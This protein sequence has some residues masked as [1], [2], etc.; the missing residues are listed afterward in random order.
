LQTQGPDDNQ[1]GK[2]L[3][4]EELAQL[5]VLVDKYSGIFT[6]VPK[7]TSVI[8]CDIHL[9]S[10]VPIKSKPYPVPQA[11]N[12]VINKEISNM[13]ALGVIER[14]NLSYASPVVM[15]KKKMGR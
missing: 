6:D 5:R 1:L 9:T 11:M 15:V 10:Q 12:K 14:S 2:Q 8:E 7:K 4:S 13:L 3:S